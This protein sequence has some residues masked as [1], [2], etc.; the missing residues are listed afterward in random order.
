LESLKFFEGAFI[1]YLQVHE[2]T[3]TPLK[4][5]FESGFMQEDY[6]HMTTGK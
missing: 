1:H 4:Y 3:I 5:V 6:K 2:S